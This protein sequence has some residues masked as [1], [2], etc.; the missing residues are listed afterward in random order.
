M[1]LHVH[2]NLFNPIW[3]PSVLHAARSAIFPNNLLAGA[4]SPPT[5]DEIIAIKKDCA[6]AIVEAIPE[7][8]RT[9]V[10]ATDDPHLIAADVEQSLDWFA[11]PYINKHLIVS[12]LE[13]I[14][15]RLFPELAGPEE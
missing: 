5:G 1:S 13:L 8:F 9:R 14:T 11:S 12:A 3:V 10:F 2:A 6:K 15:V 4:R 7:P